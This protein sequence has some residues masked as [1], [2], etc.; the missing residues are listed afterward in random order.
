[1]NIVVIIIVVVIIGL[2]IRSIMLGR[3]ARGDL[4]PGLRKLKLDAQ[5][6]EQGRPE[7]RIG[8]NWKGKSQGLI[9]IRDSPIQWVN[10]VKEKGRGGPEGS[11]DTYTNVY[12]VPAPTPSSKW[13][14]QVESVR[15]KSVPLFGRVVDLRWKSDFESE[16]VRRLNEDVSLKESL[17]RL[18][19]DV[20]MRSFPGHGYW[21]LISKQ[22]PSSW[23]GAPCRQPSPSR[24]E[25]NCYETIARHL[26]ESG[27][28]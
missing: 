19:E 10:V 28:E 12:L 3:R 9:E 25:W 26:L 24:E 20:V 15:V 14:Y 1:M 11:P 8:E 18:G 6:A 27:A 17:I 13:Q 7:E 22:Y 21:A 4:C 5:M 23:F 16:L 2:I